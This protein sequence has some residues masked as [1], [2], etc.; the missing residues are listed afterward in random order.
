MDTLL[1]KFA[2]SI[3]CSLFFLTIL[4]N[5]QKIAGIS[6]NKERQLF[7]L[8]IIFARILPVLIIFLW[9]DY[10]ATSDVKMF[11]TWAQT[12]KEGYIVYKDFPAPYAPL[13]SYI[14]AL[15]LFFYDHPNAILLLMVIIEI[16]IL[17]FTYIFYSRKTSKFEAFYHSILYLS[18]PASFVLSVISGQE[19]VWMWGMVLFALYFYQKTRDDFWVGI[20]LGI[21]MLVTKV[22][23]IFAIIIAFFLLSKKVRYIIGLALI[24]IPAL[25]LLVYL[26]GDTFLLPIQEANNPR[27]PNIWSIINPIFEVYSTIGIKNL[28]LFGLISNLFIISYLSLKAKKLKLQFHK[29]FTIIWIISICWLMLIQQSSLA[30]YCFIFLIPLVFIFGATTNKRFLIIT[31]LFSFACTIQPP[32]WWGQKMPLFK[33]IEDLSI[34]INMLEYG[35]EIF[36]VGTLLCFCKELYKLLFVEF[37]KNN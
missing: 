32:I 7:L 1:P 23:F 18:L 36:I 22:L 15:P 19:D 4:F 35:L 30:N 11:H 20:A 14:T 3:F 28:N 29:A 27:T 33:G 6:K 25:V 8:A 17:Y 12:A 21:G 37:E 24:G 2:I 5:K 16:V 26:G 31:L 34:P 9:L 10:D 13:F